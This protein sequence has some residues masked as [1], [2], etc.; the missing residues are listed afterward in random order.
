MSARSRDSHAIRRSLA[1]E[2]GAAS[3]SVTSVVLPKPA[4]AET[5]VVTLRGL[6]HPCRVFLRTPA[7]VLL[8]DS[9]D[10]AQLLLPSFARARA[11]QDDLRPT[12]SYYR[13]P[14]EP[15]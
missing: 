10:G 12:A 15:I 14:R 7:R 4:G 6:P 13:R 5:S 3:H 2:A 9:V 8:L 11:Q 1:G